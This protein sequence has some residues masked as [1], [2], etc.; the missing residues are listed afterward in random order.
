MSLS[1]VRWLLLAIG[2]QRSDF[3]ES[4]ISMLAMMIDGNNYLAIMWTKWKAR[5]QVFTLGPSKHTGW[6]PYM[7]TGIS[8]AHS[9][10]LSD[11]LLLCSAIVQS[12]FESGE[13]GEWPRDKEHNQK[14]LTLRPLWGTGVTSEVFHIGHSHRVMFLN[15]ESLP[16]ARDSILCS[17]STTIY[18]CY[19]LPV[20]LVDS[21]IFLWKFTSPLVKKLVHGGDLCT[22]KAP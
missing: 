14:G 11:Q 5:Q 8:A 3:W 9:V 10:G 4:S 15:V 22:H 19:L 18:Y 16:D 13:Q 1:Y 20:I 7:C 21:F 17:C 6:P 12:V 2:C